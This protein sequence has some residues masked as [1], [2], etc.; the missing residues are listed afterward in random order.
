MCTVV[1]CG[2]TRR[3]VMMQMDGRVNGINESADDTI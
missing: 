2:V 1:D 3:N